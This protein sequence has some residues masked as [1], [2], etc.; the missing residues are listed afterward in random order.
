MR[1][2]RVREASH[3]NASRPRSPQIFRVFFFIQ[4]HPPSCTALEND[5]MELAAGAWRVLYRMQLT[6]LREVEASHEQ[7]TLEQGWI[8]RDQT[9]EMHPRTLLSSMDLWSFTWLATHPH[10][11]RR[12]IRPC[13]DLKSGFLGVGCFSNF[14]RLRAA[15]GD[16]PPDLKN[17]EANDRWS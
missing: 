9:A 11:R 1:N 17:L 8:G 12:K 16:R 3:A 6:A 7:R 10:G 5:E 4:R 13:G 14:H 15:A 2:A